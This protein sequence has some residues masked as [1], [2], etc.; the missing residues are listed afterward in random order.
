VSANDTGARRLIDMMTEFGLKDIDK[1]AEHILTQSEKATREA[2]KALPQGE[3]SYEMPLDGYEAPIVIKSKLTVKGGKITI[4]FTGSSP[5]STRGINSPRTYTHAYSVFG[6]KA[7]IAPHVP[8]NIGSLSCFDLVTEA[9]T[10]VDPIRPSPVT[11][12]HVIGQML[13]DA[14]FGCLTQA[15]P[16]K[17]QA[18]SAGSIWILSLSSAHEQVSARETEGAQRFQVTNVGLGGIGGRPG[19]D[20]LSTTAFPVRHRRHPGRDHRGP[21]PA[22]FQ[23][24]AVSARFR[25]RR[26]ISRRPRPGHRDRQSRGQAVHHL[27]G[28]L[29]PHP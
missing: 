18:E 23:A 27:G 8:N 22:L 1:L 29:R 3:W 9:G 25:W 20:G 6:L 16:G 21:M 13:A 5:A 11:A 7:V 12:R 26:R 17:V 4:D 24:Q 10:C 15:L 19:K 2:I 14:T 28:D